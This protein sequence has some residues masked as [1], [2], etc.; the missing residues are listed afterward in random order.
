MTLKAIAG[1]FFFSDFSQSS[2]PDGKFVTLQ[3]NLSVKGLIFHIFS[4][5]FKNFYDL[6]RVL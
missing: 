6:M 5:Y 2:F 1:W 4:E 3:L